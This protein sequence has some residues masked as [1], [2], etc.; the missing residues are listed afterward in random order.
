MYRQKPYLPVH[1]VE[2]TRG[3]PMDCEF[4]AVT[5]AFGGRYRNRSPEEVVAELRGLRPLTGLL[6]AQELR[7]LRGRQHHQQ[8]RLRPRILRPHRRLQAELVRPGLDEHRQ[9]P[10]DSGA[11]PKEAAA[12]ALF[13]GLRNAFARK[14]SGLHRQQGSTARSNTSKSCQKIHDHGIG[15]DGSFVFGLDS[16]DEGVFD[17]TVDFVRKAKL[18]VAY[19]SILTPYPGTRLH[20]RLTAEGRLL[21]E[22]WSLYD[23]SHVVYRPKTLTPETL[24]SGYHQAFKETFSAPLRL[25]AALGHHRLEELLLPYEFRVSA[26]RAPAYSQ[27]GPSGSAYEARASP[28]PVVL[29]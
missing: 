16:D 2:T 19:F 10:G 1:F 9:R 6:H 15:I 17:R 26:K 22:R 13:I 14:R 27:C 29:N 24:L 18:E 3:C 21:S 4:C 23:G 5:S 7:V 12:S 28:I 11:L 8:P 25:P 20:R